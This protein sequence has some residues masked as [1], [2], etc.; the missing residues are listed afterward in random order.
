MKFCE[1][2]FSRGARQL[3]VGEGSCSYLPN[4]QANVVIDFMHCLY[5]V[6]FLK[7]NS[8]PLGQIQA[9]NLLL[10]KGSKVQLKIVVKTD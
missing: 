6:A 9:L 3:V 10:L 8:L 1:L 2:M 5:F 4:L 7:H